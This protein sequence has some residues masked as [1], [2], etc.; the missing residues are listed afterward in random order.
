[1]MGAQM[2][3]E[4]SSY[5]EFQCINDPGAQGEKRPRSFCLFGRLPTVHTG[6]D[7]CIWHKVR[8]EVVEREMAGM[9]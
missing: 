5:L 3:T 9:Y 8:R 4:A 7:V 2:S 1:M 6:Q